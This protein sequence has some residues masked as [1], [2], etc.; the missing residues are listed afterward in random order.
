MFRNSSL[1]LLAMLAA[2]AKG[3]YRLPYSNNIDVR[4]TADFVTHSSPA[5][6]MYDMKAV[7]PPA[8]IRAAAP[9]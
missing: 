3:E 9:G 6:Q 8:F 4:I 7:N 1:L 2:C 5:A